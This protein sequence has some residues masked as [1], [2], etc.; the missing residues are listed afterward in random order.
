MN[1]ETRWYLRI[2]TLHSIR[3]PKQ[4]S[5]R[6]SSPSIVRVRIIIVLIQKIGQF[7]ASKKIRN[8]VEAHGH[9]QRHNATDYGDVDRWMS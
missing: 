5:I 8:R 6:K 3:D 4:L 2:T 1:I 7:L 9:S